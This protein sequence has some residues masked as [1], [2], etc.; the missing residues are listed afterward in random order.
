MPTAGEWIF[1]EIA[2]NRV[3]GCPSEKLSRPFR[4][5]RAQQV[6]TRVHKRI[7]PR[8][9]ETSN[10]RRESQIIIE[11]LLIIYFSRL[12]SNLKEINQ[13]KDL[14][15]PFFPLLFHFRRIIAPILRPT[16]RFE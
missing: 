14:L 11:R 2:I 9:S 3:R 4:N 1:P 10:S 13:S 15:H 12:L 6:A 7:H 5:P 8:S 16:G